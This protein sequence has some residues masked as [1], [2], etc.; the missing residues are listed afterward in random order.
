MLSRAWLRIHARLVLL[1]PRRP[2][3]LVVV[4]SVLV[5]VARARA[6]ATKAPSSEMRTEHPRPML[7]RHRNADGTPKGRAPQ[8]FAPGS[9]A[10]NCTWSAQVL[11]IKRDV[12]DKKTGVLKPM[13]PGIFDVGK[14]CAANGVAFNDYCWEFVCSY[15][16]S[17]FDRTNRCFYDM[18]QRRAAQALVL[19]CARCG[20]SSDTSAH[21]EA[22]SAKHALPNH[23]AKMATYFRQG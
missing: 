1:T 22:L 12:K 15:W 23:L 4:V 9:F 5:A 21:P 11:T 14:F 20:H 7:N 3:L 2:L 10:S 16:M 6:R 13:P 19:A 8:A 18:D 17:S